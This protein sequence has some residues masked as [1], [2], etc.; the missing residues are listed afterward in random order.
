MTKEKPF[1]VYVICAFHTTV[2]FIALSLNCGSHP[3]PLQNL[4]ANLIEAQYADGLTDEQGSSTQL[5]RTLDISNLF[6]TAV[7]TAELSVNMYAHWLQVWH[8]AARNKL[9]W[10]FPK[11]ADLYFLMLYRKNAIFHK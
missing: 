7:F 1:A 3:S 6:F 8:P 9:I 5:G 10:L 2:S 11:K 4:V